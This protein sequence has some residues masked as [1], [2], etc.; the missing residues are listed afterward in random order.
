MYFSVYIFSLF[1]IFSLLIKFSLGW[2]MS[3][4]SSV[5]LGFIDRDSRHT[6]NLA[7]VAWVVYSHGGLLVSLGGVFLGLY[8]NNVA[9]YSFII[10]LL[11]DAISHGIHSLEV[12]LDSQLVVCQLNDSYRVCDPS[13]LRQF[14]R[15]QIL[16]QIFD[17]I[18]YHHIPRSSNYVSDAYA[19][20]VLDWNFSHN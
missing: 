12:H 11:C 7:S 16:E 15:V 2:Q 10:E 8:M 1:F 9:E 5:Y 6:R 17:F 20:F 13:L 18:T 14:L 19:N 3:M 4:D